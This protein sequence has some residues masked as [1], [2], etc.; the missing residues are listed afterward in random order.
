MVGWVVGMIGREVALQFF[1]VDDGVAVL[2]CSGK[3]EG[4]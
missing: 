1:E 4:Y 2:A 3:L